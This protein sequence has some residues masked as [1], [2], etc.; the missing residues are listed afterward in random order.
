MPHEIRRTVLPKSQY[1]VSTGKEKTLDRAKIRSRKGDKLGDYSVGFYKIDDAIK[2]YFDNVI[3]PNVIE[4]DEFISVPV[5]YGSPERW[6]AMQ[7]DG[8]YRDNK[9]KVL[10]PLIMFRRTSIAK[11]TEIPTSA[12]DANHPKLH[13]TFEKKYNS[14]NKYDKFSVLQGI[15]PSKEF[16]NIIMP[17]Y[18]TL[19]YEAIIFTEYLE[20]MNKIVEAIHYSEGAYW[21]DENRFKFRCTIDSFD[22]SIELDTA[23]DRLVKT[24]FNMSFLGYIIPDSINKELSLEDPNPLSTYSPSSIMMMTEVDNVSQQFTVPGA[25][26]VVSSAAPGSIP[27]VHV[28]KDQTFGSFQTVYDYLQTANEVTGSTINTDNVIFLNTNLVDPPTNLRSQNT[29]DFMVFVN[30]QRV[31]DDSIVSIVDS[32]VGGASRIT[33]NFNTTKLNYTLDP[34]DEVTLWGKVSGSGVPIT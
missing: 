16:Y 34:D 24:S 29:S 25:A 10:L 1:E 22:N 21:G 33:V 5:I 17:K 2:Y 27:S 28:T 19:T 7:R 31:G 6:K 9:G 4:D 20:Q 26:E 23:G 30:G 11:N 3:K 18:V 32:V 12:L 8:Y 14:K 13:Y 15:S